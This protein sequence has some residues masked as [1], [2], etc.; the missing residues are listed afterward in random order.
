MTSLPINTQEVLKNDGTDRLNGGLGNDTFV[1]NTL[2]TGIDIIE[3]F[4]VRV[5]TI[6]IDADGFGAT[7][8]SQF[9]F[10][11]SNG[12]LSFGSQQFATLENFANLQ[13]FDV[14]ADIQLV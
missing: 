9:S 5:D 3:D 10:D 8:I 13:G 2:S 7:D 6:R 12:A 4:E 1:F 11:Q 14:N